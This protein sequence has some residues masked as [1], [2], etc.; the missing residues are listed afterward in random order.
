MK[1]VATDRAPKPIG[2]YSQAII[3]SNGLAFISG[4]IGI[5]P[6]TGKLVSGGVLK[7]MEQLLKNLDAIL[8][9][10]GCGWS[11]IVRCEIFLVDIADFG[12]VNELYAQ[13]FE[14]PPYP[15][16]FTVQVAA[17]PAGA[18]IEIACIVEK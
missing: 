17:L 4:Q 7:E 13:K 14:K 8:Q 5:D 11:K 1:Q 3:S 16:R 6:D 10:A 12:K 15:A 9:E 2:P 18:R